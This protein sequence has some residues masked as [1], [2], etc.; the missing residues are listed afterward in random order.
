M[1][2]VIDSTSH[3]HWKYHT[4]LFVYLFLCSMLCHVWM[5]CMC[6]VA[7]HCYNDM[8]CMCCVAI[9]C[10]NDMLCMCCVAIHCYNDMLCMCCVAI[11]CYNDML[12]I[13]S[14]MMDLW[15]VCKWNAVMEYI[16][17]GS[18]LSAS[19]IPW[20][21]EELKAQIMAGVKSTFCK[22]LCTEDAQ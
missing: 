2:R 19:D 17:V 11:H 21:V 16:T 14:C 13:L 3:L 10:Y 7:I 1:C 8:L 9:H 12:H 18:G 20:Q 15:A 5:L 4:A 6:C 22:T